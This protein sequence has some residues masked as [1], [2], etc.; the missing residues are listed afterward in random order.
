MQSRKS[1][2][3][4]AGARRPHGGRVCA[5]TLGG[6]DGGGCGGGGSGG[7]GDRRDDS[8]FR[9]PPCTRIISWRSVVPT[10][11]TTTTRRVSCT[12][13]DGRLQV[14]AY[15]FACK[16]E[17]IYA[18]IRSTEKW[19][20]R[21]PRVVRTDCAHVP[22][23]IFRQL[24]C[25]SVCLLF[26]TPIHHTP[27]LVSRAHRNASDLCVSDSTVW[28]SAHDDAATTAAPQQ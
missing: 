21:E 20:R 14:F 12:H 26:I 10:V 19:F 7:G 18:T 5:S 22:H 3:R 17:N 9:C 15:R 13:R 25:S 2:S 16:N 24:T 1:P 8:R 4:P 28:C 27:P 23:R 6:V 11:A